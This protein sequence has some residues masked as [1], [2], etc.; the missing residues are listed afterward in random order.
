M[1]QLTLAKRY[2]K[3][4]L[5]VAVERD[6]VGEIEEEIV[7]LKD[8]YQNDEYLGRV[9]ENPLIEQREK[10]SIVQDTLTDHFCEEILN[11]LEIIIEK[12]RAAIIPHIADAYDRLADDYH[13]VVRVRARSAQPV[14]E[15]E[16]NRLREELQRLFDDQSVELTCEVKPDLLAGLRI[17]IGDHV[18][19]GSLAGRIDGLEESLTEQKSL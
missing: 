2:A 19:D 16:Q 10:Q 9:L 3:A 5:D 4:L 7:Q 14:T 12:D 8:L 6:R 18:L 13:G 11:L 17:Q 15:E 1:S